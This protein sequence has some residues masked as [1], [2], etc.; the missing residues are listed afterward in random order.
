MLDDGRN[1]DPKNDRAFMNCKLFLIPLYTYE[2][3]QT[4]LWIYCLML[5]STG[6]QP[7]HWIFENKPSTVLHY[8]LFAFVV[9]FFG[10]LSSLA[11]HELIHHKDWFHKVAGT[12]PYIQFSYTHFWEEHTKGHHKNIGTPMDPVCANVGTS[13]YY[14]IAKAVVGTHVA[15]WNRHADRLRD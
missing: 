13:C 2:L 6:Y 15:T 14:A 7:D 1:Y 8:V 3:S 9:G 10:A 4:V 12:I 5:F 11:G